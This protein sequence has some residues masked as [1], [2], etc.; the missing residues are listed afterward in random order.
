MGLFIAH[1]L[2]TGRY[3]GNIDINDRDTGGTEVRLTL[4]KNRMT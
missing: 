4:A 2:T 1:R 3:E